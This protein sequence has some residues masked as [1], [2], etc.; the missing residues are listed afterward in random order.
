M[1]A[2][3]GVL[4]YFNLRLR[5][6]YFLPLSIYDLGLFIILCSKFMP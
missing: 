4:L 6:N 5:L 2:C 3:C 1:V